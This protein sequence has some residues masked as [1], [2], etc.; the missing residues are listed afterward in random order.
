MSIVVDR[1]LDVVIRKIGS[2]SKAERAGKVGFDLH[3]LSTAISASIY[4]VG[5]EDALTSPGETVLG[6]IENTPNRAASGHWRAADTTVASS[7][8]LNT[9]R[10][11]NFIV[12]KIENKCP[13]DGP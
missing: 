10:S 6:V 5:N 3:G 9:E 1:N 4:Q 11:V 13:T 7:K 12:S 8:N 2:N